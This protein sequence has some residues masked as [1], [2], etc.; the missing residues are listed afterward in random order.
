MKKNASF[1]SIKG[2]KGNGVFAQSG[3]RRSFLKRDFNLSTSKGGYGVMD[4]LLGL[5]RRRFSK[6]IWK[7]AKRNFLKRFPKEL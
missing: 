5:T 1:L 4:T 3:R 6:P 7:S 2:F